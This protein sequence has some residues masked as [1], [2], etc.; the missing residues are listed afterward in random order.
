M[1]NFNLSDWVVKLHQ[2]NDDMPT[3]VCGIA[4][5]GN[6]RGRIENWEWKWLGRFRCE[7][8]APGIIGYGTRYNRM[9]ALQ[10]AVEDFIHKAIQA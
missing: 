1:L 8:K 6:T 3:N 10:S 4:C 2:W 5:V 9:S 7:S